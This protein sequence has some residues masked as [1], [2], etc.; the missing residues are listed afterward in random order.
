VKLV[1]RADAWFGTPDL[2]DWCEAH[3]VAYAIAL[4]ANAVL[5]REAKRWREPAE[6]AAA[7]AATKRARRFGRFWYQAQG[8][9][10]AREVIVKVEVTPHATSVRFVLV[11]ALKGPPRRVY[12][13]YGR[14]GDC[15]NRIKEM[16]QALKSDRTSCMDFASNKVRLMLA[17]VAYV[18]FQGL[19]RLA[20]QTGLAHAQVET[21]RLA[22]IK[23][24]ALVKESQ[25][26][27]TVSLCRAC[28]TQGLWR[29]LARRLGLAAA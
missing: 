24:A 25:R 9:G 6:A 10:R 23:I 20:R 11:A 5:Q 19:R 7:K 21:L 13:F 15:E 29:Q 27:V 26:R 14:R 22:V 18:L 8:W 4:P 17:A 1:L 2:Y 28:P 16:K 3:R 12:H